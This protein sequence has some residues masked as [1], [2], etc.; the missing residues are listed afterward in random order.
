MRWLAGRYAEA[1]AAFHRKSLNIEPPPC[2]I[3]LTLAHRRRRKPASRFELY[4]EFSVAS[5]ALDSAG[6]EQL[7]NLCL[8][9]PPRSGGRAGQ[10]SNRN[11]AD[12]AFSGITAGMP[13]IWACPSAIA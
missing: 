3:R 6:R 1:K 4:L 7:S 5:G 12:L 10:T 8:G 2:A 9:G 13:F 11:R